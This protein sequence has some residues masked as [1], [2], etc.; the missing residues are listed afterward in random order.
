MVWDWDSEGRKLLLKILKTS[1]RPY[2]QKGNGKIQN[3]FRA[4][5][6]LGPKPLSQERDRTISVF[7]SEII[8]SEDKKK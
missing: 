6:E 8:I 2:K 1:P 3:L 4:G 7:I 5:Q